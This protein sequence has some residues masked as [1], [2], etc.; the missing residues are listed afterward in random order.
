M[1]VAMISPHYRPVERG[2]SVTVDRICRHL[3]GLGCDVDIYGLSGPG[4]E[5]TIALVAGGGYDICHAFHAWHCGTVA[6]EISRRSGIP[7]LVTLTG[8]DVYEAL[9]DDR[10]ETTRSVLAGAAGIVAFHDVV[11]D[12]LEGAFPGK[13]R[14]RI[15]VIPQGVDLPAAE[16]IPSD[17][18]EFRFL[19]PA[20]LR[21]VKC[22][23]FPLAP[24]ARL[25]AVDRRVRL[26]V[27][28]PV[29][30][31]GYAAAFRA[32]L[33]KYPFAGYPG[34]VDHAS[35]PAMYRHTHVVLNTSRFEGGMAN[36]LLEGMSWGR[37]VLAADIEGNRSLVTDGVNGFLYRDER[38]FENRAGMLL[39]DPELC[40]KLGR[41]GRSM[42]ERDHSPKE[43]A[44][45]YLDLYRG[46]LDG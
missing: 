41:S 29:I 34:A 3:R 44:A 11:A 38:E 40:K 20:G 18:D 17:A 25:H 27:V 1:R 42:V 37:P 7:Y 6:V 5:D 22:V 9:D 33:S 32:E 8:S 10:Q 43:E 36:S 31:N 45:R 2:N 26:T 16:P 39:R 30:D 24:L 4:S 14:A 28:G 35:M 46:I 15:S 13:L 12:R 19:L 21:P 23:Q